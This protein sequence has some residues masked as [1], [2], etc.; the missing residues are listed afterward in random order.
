MSIMPSKRTT[1]MYRIQYSGAWV[2]R[3]G[4]SIVESGLNV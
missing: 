2:K 3:I 1:S 4:Y